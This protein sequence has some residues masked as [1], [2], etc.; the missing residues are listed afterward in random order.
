MAPDDISDIDDGFVREYE[1]EVKAAFQ[2]QGSLLMNCVRTK[3]NVKGKSTT[4][5]NYGKITAKQKTRN[6][7]VPRS[8]ATHTPVECT[9]EDW[10]AS[11]PVDELDE[12]KT[13]NDERQLAAEGGAHALGREA[14]GQIIEALG[15]T[16]KTV[17]NYSTGVTKALI[18]EALESLD[19][20]DVPQKDRFGIMRPHGFNELKN[21]AEVKSA[22]YTGDLMPW[23]KG[24]EAFFWNGVMWIKHTGLAV[25]STDDVDSF[26]FQKMAVGHA[27]GQDVKTRIDWDTRAQGWNIVSK[28]SGNACLIDTLGVVKLKVDNDTAIT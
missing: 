10:Y 21:I 13:N 19:D 23:L 16:S 4:F 2:R 12:L 17:G 11:V 26:I 22:D 8:Q 18:L 20:D 25:V 7:D 15:T 5:Q 27:S 24:Q 9:L 1:S 14:D 28:M 3:K 6:G